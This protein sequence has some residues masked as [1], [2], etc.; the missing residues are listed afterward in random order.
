M[1]V[2][3]EVIKDGEKIISLTN[4]SVKNVKFDSDTDITLIPKLH[5]VVRNLIVTGLINSD[6]VGNPEINSVRQLAN[7]AII[8]EYCDCYCDVTIELSDAKGDLVKSE[9]FKDMFVVEYKETFDIE[10]GNGL[11]DIHMRER[12]IIED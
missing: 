4:H 3:F 9:E 1:G 5:G 8:P 10:H 11:F 12:E 6:L 2:L 7:W